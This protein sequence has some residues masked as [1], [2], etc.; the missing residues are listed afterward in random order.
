MVRSQDGSE[1]RLR[2]T[3][4]SGQLNGPILASV[5]DS[6]VAWGYSG[7]P[8]CSPGPCPGMMEMEE[9]CVLSPAWSACRAKEHGAPDGLQELA[10]PPEALSSQIGV[11]RCQNSAHIQNIRDVYNTTSQQK[12]VPLRDSS[13][14]VRNVLGFIITRLNDMKVAGVP[15]KPHHTSV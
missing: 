9:C 10:H 1:G 11:L 2:P 8:P 14:L 6:A 5:N 12:G 7:V 13:H 4:E 3:G 15:E